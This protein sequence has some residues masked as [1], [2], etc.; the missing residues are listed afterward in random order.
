MQQPGRSLRASAAPR[1]R[2]DSE[3]GLPTQSS[4]YPENYLRNGRSAGTGAVLER[5]A[6]PRVARGARPARGPESGVGGPVRPQRPSGLCIVAA[7][8]RTPPA[9]DSVKKTRRTDA[10]LIRRGG[11]TGKWPRTTGG[12]TALPVR[13]G[14]APVRTHRRVQ[15]SDDATKQKGN[16]KQLRS[17]EKV[18]KEH[19]GSDGPNLHTIPRSKKR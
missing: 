19:G 7:P 15:P 2:A 14:H 17:P 11:G 12:R 5:K 10:S 4:S 1:D 6:L 16:S 3:T 9:A 8:S 18:I 13:S